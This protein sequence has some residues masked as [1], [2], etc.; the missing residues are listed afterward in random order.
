M[1]Q[2]LLLLIDG[3]NVVV[4]SVLQH[5]TPGTYNES[6]N[7]IYL[8]QRAFDNGQPLT[9]EEFIFLLAVIS[10]ELT[11]KDN[12]DY[13]RGAGRAVA[14]PPPS[15]QACLDA[16]DDCIDCHTDSSKNNAC[17]EVFANSNAF[18]VLCDLKNNPVFELTPSQKAE[19]QKRIDKS[20]RKARRAAMKCPAAVASCGCTLPPPPD[21]A[22]PFPHQT[23]IV[24][25][26]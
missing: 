23:V 7:T 18:K 26:F 9:G 11:H 5:G 21:V 3:A 15:T 12:I 22:P 6:T 24:D 20:C 13:W 16:Y 8:S 19:L 10:H 1:I 14:C 4:V 2:G 25:L 17:V